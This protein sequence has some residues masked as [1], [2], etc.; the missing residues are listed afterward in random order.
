MAQ[1]Q[2]TQ[3]APERVYKDLQ[4][5]FEWIEDEASATLILMLPGFTKE[6]LRV[7]VTSKGVLRINCERQG[8]QNMW[9]RFGKEFPIPQY[10]DTNDVN[11]KFERGVLSI[12]F[13]KLI[14]PDNK[15]QEQETIT[16]PPQKEAS[17]ARQSSDEPKAPTQAQV[18]DEQRETP[19]KKEMKPISDEK[20]KNKIEEQI[21]NDQKKN[22]V[23]PIGDEKEKNKIEEQIENDQKNVKTN[24]ETSEKKEV[25]KPHEG[26]GKRQ[27]K[28]TQRLKTRVLDFNISLRSRDDKDDDQVGFDFVDTRPKRGKMLMNM[29]VATLLVLVL[30]IYVKNAFWA[31]SK[32]S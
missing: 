6:Q 30:G 10:C 31:S 25:V 7:Q 18:I 14:T 12:K 3:P 20:E 2:K 16:N 23:E 17:I 19:K 22:E 29:F 5:Y 13:P 28:I 1:I 26:K 24:D 11:A 4:P 21:E 9:H 15:A 8:I 27:G 32:S